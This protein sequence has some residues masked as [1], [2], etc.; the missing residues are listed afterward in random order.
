MLFTTAA[1]PVPPR[2]LDPHPRSSSLSSQMG[3][4]FSRQN[5]PLSPPSASS[6]SSTSYS[7]SS[8][9]T[10][11][12][13]TMT[14]PHTSTS[15]TSAKLRRAFAAHRKKSDDGRGIVKDHNPTPSSSGRNPILMIPS[16]FSGKK[17]TP[18]P[19][20]Q[21]PSPPPPRLPPKPPSML[22]TFNA[23]RTDQRNSLIPLSPGITSALAFMRNSDER[24]SSVARGPETDYGNE[25]GGDFSLLRKRSSSSLDK[26]DWRKSD[27]TVTATST[28]MQRPVSVAESVQSTFTVVPTSDVGLHDF[29]DGAS[30]R[31]HPQMGGGSS[32]SNPIRR[33]S[34]DTTDEQSSSSSPSPSPSP[35]PAPSLSSASSS[36]S[37]DVRHGPRPSVTNSLATSPSHNDIHSRYAAWSTTTTDPVVTAQ[38]GY[39]PNPSPFPHHHHHPQ[40]MPTNRPTAHSHTSGHQPSSSS[41][42]S[43]SS[44]RQPAISLTGSF[45]PAGLAKRAVE[46]MGRAWGGI[47]TNS[48]ATGGTTSTHSVG[49][50]YSSS[51]SGSM[52]GPSSYSRTST[53]EHFQQQPYYQAGSGKGFGSKPRRTQNA[54]SGAWSVAS[55]SVGSSAE[56]DAASVHQSSGSP[57]SARDGPHL[58][59]QV[60][61][62]IMA[63]G[64]VFGKDLRTCTRETAIG[65]GRPHL[66]GHRHWG[67]GVKNWEEREVGTYLKTLEKRM[68]PAIVVRCAQHLLLWG[69]QEEGLFRYVLLRGVVHTL[70]ILS[71][72]VSVVGHFMYRSCVA[73]LT[74]VGKKVSSFSFFSESE[75]CNR[76]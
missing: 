63:S 32:N 43:S 65:A 70:I 36:G 15:T 3:H 56:A 8:T 31:W 33:G 76:G 16:V 69:V 35:S 60:R 59:Q 73:S 71:P 11:A 5:H 42:S 75:T 64:I 24:G 62:P 28:I 39:P 38:R 14:S 50:G 72:I 45:A 44:S 17:N 47:S 6:S 27:A 54:P 12:T 41:S 58:G 52:S 34:V 18:T 67:D 74:R 48:N 66:Q 51:S 37:V 22:N 46:K 26:E 2:S 13:S 10:T 30:G 61:R 57:T 55:S 20:P 1:P 21:P 19:I 25:I 29:T 49:S 68:V 53:P 7:I 40:P 9:G 23:T 4:S